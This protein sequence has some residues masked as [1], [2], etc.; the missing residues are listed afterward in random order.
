[1]STDGYYPELDKLEAMRESD[2]WN[3]TDNAKYYEAYLLQKG[4]GY[5][6]YDTGEFRYRPTEMGG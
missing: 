1:M 2:S 6:D 3:N 5:R 4:Q